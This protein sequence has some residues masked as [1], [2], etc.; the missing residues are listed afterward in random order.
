MHVTCIQYCDTRGPCCETNKDPKLNAS[1]GNKRQQNISYSRLFK[2][3]TF[4]GEVTIGA[5]QFYNHGT[6]R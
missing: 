5:R 6:Y 2:N 3:V 1:I 4:V